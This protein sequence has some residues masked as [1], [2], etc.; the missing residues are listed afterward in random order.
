VKVVGGDDQ[1]HGES[2]VQARDN[3]DEVSSKGG[4]EE[5]S[6]QDLYGKALYIDQEL[7]TDS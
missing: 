6:G 7:E 2:R 1:R 5:F 3:S 4:E